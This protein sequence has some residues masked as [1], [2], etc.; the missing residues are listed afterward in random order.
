MVIIFSVSGL[1][2]DALVI[3]ILLT[4]LKFTLRFAKQSKKG[5]PFSSTRAQT[6]C[7]FMTSMYLGGPISILQATLV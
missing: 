2:L 3:R 6:G 5:L 4:Q 7:K 1:D